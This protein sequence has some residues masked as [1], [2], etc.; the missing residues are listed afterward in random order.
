[1]LGRMAARAE[2]IT[3]GTTPTLLTTAESDHSA[4]SSALIKAITVGIEIGGPDVAV[5]SGYPLDQGEAVGADLASD[6][7]Y[8][9]V[10]SGTGTVA[11]LRTGA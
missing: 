6:K 10:A 7:I 5:G 9:R 1:M 11:I 3:V 8:G 4:G 2:R